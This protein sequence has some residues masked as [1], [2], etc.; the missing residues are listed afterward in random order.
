MRAVVMSGV[1]GPEVLEMREVSDLRAGAGQV[2]VAV[3]AVGLNRAD[4]MQRR[5]FYPAP[6]GVAPDILGLEYAGE[7]VELGA[8]VSRWRLGDRVMGIVGGGA[9]A[10]EVVVHEREAL[11]APERLS[12]AEVAAIPEVFLTAFDALCL[13]AELGLGDDVLIHA[14]GSGVG[15]AAVQ[16]ARL[17][18]ARSFGTA[19]AA[20]KLEKCRGLGLDIGV[21]PEGGSF[22]PQVLQIQP[23]G[24]R[25]VMDF[26]GAAYLAQNLEV[27]RPQG[28]LLLVG[29][30][31]GAQASVDL[32]LVLRKRLRVVGT[33]LRSRPLEEKIAL[34]QAFERRVL[35]HLASG[36][37]RPVLDRTFDMRDLADAHRAMEQNEN[38]GKLVALW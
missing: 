28:T 22:A 6:A 14:V 23:K 32:G 7:V 15:S 27:L 16:L 2:K 19:R 11:P 24:V 30:M 12:W 4:V 38:F 31:G 9:C 10:E 33:V 37:L 5:G 26:V 36:S 20:W 21:E 25:V 8:G 35:P 3:R 17:A 29:M 13:Q 1:G 18:G 34:A